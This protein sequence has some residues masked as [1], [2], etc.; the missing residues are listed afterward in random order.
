MEFNKRLIELRKSKGL[1]QADVAKKIGVARATYGAYEQGN[2]QPDFDTL[3]SIANF[4]GVTTDYLLG[5]SNTIQEPSSSYYIPNLQ[6]QQN[7]PRI[8]EIVGMSIEELAQKM[9]L[10]QATI[11][12][13]ETGKET[14]SQLQVIELNNVLSNSSELYKGMLDINATGVGIPLLKS[15]SLDNFTDADF[16][17]LEEIKKHPVLF[18]ELSVNPEKKIREIVR[19]HKMKKLLLEEDE[20]S[21]DGFGD[22]KD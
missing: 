7:L 3:Q 1:Y 17:L 13:W 4:F 15:R 9:N 5:R 22:L 16:L 18:N 20:E 8:R 21:G 6:V 2:R 14:P 11:N 10:S 19:L 12:A